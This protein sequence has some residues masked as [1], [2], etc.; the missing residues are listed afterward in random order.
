M[1]YYVAGVYDIG[2]Q[3][4]KNE[5]HCGFV[6]L[7]DDHMFCVVADG[8][9]SYD[10]LYQP[11]YL[12]THDIFRQVRTI[13]QEHRDFFLQ[14]PEYFMRMFML[15]A[16]DLL[17]HCKIANEELYSG[18]EASLTCCFLDAER[19]IYVAHSG[20]T[21]LYIM[22]DG[23]ITQLTEDHTTAWP[24]LK[25]GTITEP[26]YVMHPGSKNLTSQIGYIVDPRIDTFSGKLKTH[27]VVLMTTDGI[28]Y[29][30]PPENLVELV[31]RGGAPAE[32]CNA[33]IEAARD[34]VK[35]PDNM[36]AVVVSV[37]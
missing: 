19:H 10:N 24:L 21:R 25:D 23:N 15:R 14:D 20:N 5:D 17:L 6:D 26:D 22:R 28:H 4:L 2:Y 33:L 34:V 16:G 35:Y 29:A 13:F 18:Y 11:A 37:G 1:P 27:D 36:A 31:L 12:V 8:S 7:G 9:G 32:S 30:L 3:R